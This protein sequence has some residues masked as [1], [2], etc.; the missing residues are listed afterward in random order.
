L[1]ICIVFYSWYARTD[2]GDVARVEN[3]TVISTENERETIPRPKDGVVGT[4]GK[5]MSPN[6]L[7]QALDDRMP[8]CMKGR[9]N[10]CTNFSFHLLQY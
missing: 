2:P 8:G 3:K 10:N 6:N 4:L 7:Q 1:L 9:N 5:W